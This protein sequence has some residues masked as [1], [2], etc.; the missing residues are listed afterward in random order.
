[1]PREQVLADVA[2]W[3][4]TKHGIKLVGGLGFENA[5]TLAMTKSRAK[6]LAVRDVTALARHAPQLSIAGDYE[7][8]GR[9][10]WKALRETYR[11]SFRAQRQMQPEFMY[12]AVAA[13]EIDVISAYTSDGRVAQFDLQTIDD[14]RGAIP[15][16]DAIVLV[17]PKRA[18]DTALMTA[19][20]PLLNAINVDAMREANRR[21]SGEASE[22]PDAAAHWLW[23]KISKR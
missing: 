7:F 3:L 10:E 17:S 20:A 22:T 11:L 5:Y 6:E 8:F 16:Y 1:L 2:Q 21:V 4:D 15:P 12:P 13:R 19:I 18:G 9:P 23:E 14:D